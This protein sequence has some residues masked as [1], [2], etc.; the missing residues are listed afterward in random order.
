MPW[1]IKGHLGRKRKIRCSGAGYSGQPCAEC[2]A[3]GA[4]CIAQGILSE[5]DA[6]VNERLRNHIDELESRLKGNPPKGKGRHEGDSPSLESLLS[7]INTPSEVNEV[8]HRSSLVVDR[9]EEELGSAGAPLVRLLDNPALGTTFHP[10]QDEKTGRGLDEHRQGSC[11]LRQDSPENIAAVRDLCSYLPT[12]AELNDIF[13]NHSSWWPL[14][15]ETLGLVWGDEAGTSLRLFAMQALTAR[16]PSLLGILLTSLAISTGDLQRYLPAVE[17][18]IVNVDEYAG[19]EYGLGC[20]MALGLCYISSLQPR[21]AWTIYR[22]ANTLLQLNGLHVRRKSENHELLFWQLFHADRWV[23]LMIGLPY[24]ISDKFCNTTI[25]S[26]N[27]ISTGTWLYRQ[28]GLL[29][30]QV[31][32]CL[33]NVKGPTLA[34][35]LQ[36]EEEMDEIKAQL[37]SGYLDLSEIR[38][39]PDLADKYTRLYRLVHFHQLRAHVHLPFLLRSATQE[40][41]KFTRE[42]CTNDSRLLLEAFLEIFDTDPSV[43]AYGTV[44]NF[45]AFVAAVILLMGVTCYRDSKAI[46]TPSTRSQIDTDWR[47]LY[48]VLDAIKHGGATRAAGLICRKCYTALEQLVS[49]AHST[50]ENEPPKRV[51]LPYFGTL[52]I[53]RPPA[54]QTPSQST[55]ASVES[56]QPSIPLNQSDWISDAHQPVTNAQTTPFNVSMDGLAMSSNMPMYYDQNMAPGISLAYNGPFLPEGDLAGYGLQ[57]VTGSGFGWFDEFDMGA[58]WSW[59][60]ADLPPTVGT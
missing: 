59:L 18:R 35:V 8:L 51:V 7:N 60:T 14:Y 6:A 36:I 23:S 17:R 40:R 34:A 2:K 28:L 52:I 58:D 25:P 12:E 29:T 3:R 38:N 57:A 13:D 45:T 32:D 33:Q 48:R 42:S 54:Q 19:C 22:R 30:G 39:C 44:L 47:I 26:I 11:H 43:A 24:C 50:N 5:D 10:S 31:I 16:H 1:L 55:G 20:L 9:P 27:T 49:S 37:P 53:S 21:R 15:R 46:E 56:T 41:Y 4:K